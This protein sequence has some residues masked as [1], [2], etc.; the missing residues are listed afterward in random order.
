MTDAT[1]EA[2][3]DYVR[4]LKTFDSHEHLVP[5]A[6]RLADRMDFTLFLRMY[7]RTDL[8]VAGMSPADYDRMAG[9]SPLSEDERFALLEPYLPL[10]SQSSYYRAARIA[11][12]DIYGFDDITRQTYRPIGEALRQANT[13]GLYRRILKG[14][15][16]LGHIVNQKVVIN[17]EGGLFHCNA[18]V[19]F[20]HGPSLAE[21]HERFREQ[22]VEL[23][24][25]DFESWLAALEMLME[26]W[27]RKNILALKMG[28]QEMRVPTR[29]R[30]VSLIK[31]L[32]GKG[33]L[34]PGEA[35]SLRAF[36]ADFFLG[37]ARRHGY[38]MAVHTGPA[39]SPG[40]DFRQIDPCHLM[41]W[42]QAYGDVQFDMYHM[43]VPFVR[44]AGFVAKL[45]PN[46]TANLCWAH[47]V[48][49]R[50]V[51]HALDEWL[52]FLPFNRIIGFGGDYSPC[53]EKSYGALEMTRA[54][55]VEVMCRRIGRG[56]MDLDEAKFILKRI[57]V[58]NGE[59]LYGLAGAPGD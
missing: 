42:A 3:L 15:C 35:A 34:P 59:E 31:K 5:E 26:T 9:D 43:G 29:T 13:P 1:T 10:L 58:D 4:T 55:L 39:A 57:L 25:R 16:D 22:E 23:E 52:D 54:N 2:L 41:P 14:R 17:D 37:K 49:P 7:V 28:V 56:Q 8:I 38:V 51:V 48:A 11:L 12:R 53:V 19:G 36:V 20:Y 47:V 44:Q 24:I 21:M 32:V 6:E 27:R 45:H 30:A 46:V 18:H 33:R 40:K 50:M